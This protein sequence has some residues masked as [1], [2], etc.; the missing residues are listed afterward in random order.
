MMNLPSDLPFPQLIQAL[1][2]TDQPLNPLYLYRLS[3]LEER[4]LRQLRDVWQQIPLWRRQA[5]MEDV[6]ELS[7]KDMLLSFVALSR[8]ALQD[9]DARVRLL[10]VQTLWDYEE[11]TLIPVLLDVLAK[12]T[13][14]EVRAAAAGGLGHYVYAGELEEIP[15]RTLHKIEEAL[16]SVMQSS[17]P[18]QVR[19]SALEALGYSSREEVPGLIKDAYAT[20]DKLWKASALF[21]MGCSADVEWQPQVLEM[22]QHT[23]PLLR[24]EAARA[25]GELELREAIPHLVELLDDPD[26]NTRHASIWALSQIGGEGVRETLEKL[27]SET[28]DEAELELLDEALEN[29]AFT[30]GAQLMPL[31]DLPEAEDNEDWYEEYDLEETDDLYEEDEDLEY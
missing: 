25:A 12:D 7:G 31:F 21:A 14:N 13:D 24:G 27:S 30:E 17:D 16:L 5:L 4:E 2:E 19:R 28:E 20:D 15:A 18:P 29:L 22:L 8:L 11:T 6:E 26:D 23:L 10:A 3:D 1:L 9:E